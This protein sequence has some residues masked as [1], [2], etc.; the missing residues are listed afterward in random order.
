MQR[1]QFIKALGVSSI[2]MVGLT[3]GGSASMTEDS[4]DSIPAQASQYFREFSA[5]TIGDRPADIEDFWAGGFDVQ[6]DEFT[7]WECLGEERCL[8]LQKSGTGSDA[9]YWSGGPEAEDIELFTVFRN[10]AASEYSNR[11]RLLAR[12]TDDSA[13]AGGNTQFNLARITE[14]TPDF[15]ELAEHPADSIDAGRPIAQR[16]RVVDDQAWVKV[17]PYGGREPR[18]WTLGPVDTHVALAGGV[19]LL[20]FGSDSAE[21]DILCW[22][23]SAATL[24]DEETWASPRDPT[25]DFM[26]FPETLTHPV[27]V[28]ERDIWYPDGWSEFRDGGDR[29]HRAVDIYENWDDDGQHHR[30]RTEDEDGYPESGAP[31]FAAADGTIRDWMQG[32]PDSHEMTPGSGGGYTI[33]VETDAY[34]YAYLHLGPDEQGRHEEAFAPHPDENRTLGPGDTVEAGQHIGWL[35]ESGVTGSGPH[36]HFEIRDNAGRLEDDQPSDMDQVG[37]AA[38]PRYDPYPVLRDAE[39]R[40]DVPDEA[41][42][43]DIDEVVDDDTETTAPVIDR[44]DLETKVNRRWA[45]V[46]VTWAVSDDD[47]NLDAVTTAFDDGADVETADISGSTASGKH[48]LRKRRGH[49]ETV[50]VTLTVTDTDGNKRSETKQIAVS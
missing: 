39:R 41:A 29:A 15:A 24:D 23:I 27:A 42:A 12:G 20:S 4:E 38:G 33:H 18:R 34:V 5:D 1:R 17:W 43:T 30:S 28:D 32:H 50:A 10:E 40:G 31:V 36:L 22:E 3:T 11:F 48:D 7:R 35:G 25:L 45:R 16:F 37:Y 44:F 6:V 26:S 9:V 2:G 19:G 8:R 13:V 47:G 46:V 21:T 49:K 14:H